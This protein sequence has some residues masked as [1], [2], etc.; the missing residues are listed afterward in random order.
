MCI[1]ICVNPL[2]RVFGGNGMSGTKFA[3]HVTDTHYTTDF[4]DRAIYLGP[5]FFASVLEDN[6]W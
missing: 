5:D 3:L 6:T 4:F 2:Y 1:K